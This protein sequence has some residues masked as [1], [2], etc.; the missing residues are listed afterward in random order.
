[1]NRMDI[2]W[3][4]IDENLLE[5]YSFKIEKKKSRPEIMNWREFQSLWK[6]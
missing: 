6:S 5:N 1:M 3:I 2:L 4:D